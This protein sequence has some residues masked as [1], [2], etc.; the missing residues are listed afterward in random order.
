[1]F[2]DGSSRTAV[3]SRLMRPGKPF[4]FTNS[5]TGEGIDELV[6]LLFKMALFDKEAA[7]VPVK[8]EAEVEIA[9]FAWASYVHGIGLCQIGTHFGCG[10]EVDLRRVG[11][12]SLLR[13]G[14]GW[15]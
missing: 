15:I 5:L 4:V 12:V 13:H 14:G 10:V 9:V 8:F 11:V 1:M 7:S 6:D 2:I 3:Y